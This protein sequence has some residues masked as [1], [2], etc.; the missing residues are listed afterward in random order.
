MCLLRSLP[1]RLTDAAVQERKEEEDRREIEMAAGGGTVQESQG[2]KR[3]AREWREA[4][5]RLNL[6]HPL[7]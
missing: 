7:R 4:G 1:A 3:N 2:G 6:S 5:V